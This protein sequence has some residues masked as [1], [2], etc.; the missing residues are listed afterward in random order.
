MMSK[1]EYDNCTKSLYKH[2]M[3]PIVKVESVLGDPRFYDYIDKNQNI[4]TRLMEDDS[5]YLTQEMLDEF[6][7]Q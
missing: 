6:Y 3:I 1:Y 4:K 2:S 5:F 7:K